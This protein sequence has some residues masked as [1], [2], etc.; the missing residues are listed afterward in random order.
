M[1]EIFEKFLE[2]YLQNKAVRT[3]GFGVA[4]DITEDNCTVLRDGQ[5]ELL[6]VRFHAMDTKPGSHHITIPADKSS[7]MY[8]IIDNQEAEAVILMCSEI[9]RI[10]YKVG[11]A[12]YELDKDGHLIQ[13]DNEKL[14][15]AITDL[16]N[17]V[18]KI[19]VINGRSPNVL[20]LTAIKNRINKILR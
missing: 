11:K 6:D 20:A 12:Q 10:I 18:A 14:S 13:F 8:A 7:V 4:T 3:V 16:I 17:E 1:D 2:K 15:T 19:I 5:P 9:D